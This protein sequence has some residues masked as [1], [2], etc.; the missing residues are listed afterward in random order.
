MTT[1][2]T[3]RG[4][5]PGKRFSLEHSLDPWH[6]WVRAMMLLAL[7]LPLPV[8]VSWLSAQGLAAEL[9]SLSSALLFALLLL[10]TWAALSTPLVL[11]VS[12][13]S[14]TLTLTAR[15]EQASRPQ[16]LAFPALLA[17]AV[18]G[19]ALLIPAVAV[20]W[21]DLDIAG[22][23]PHFSLLALGLL[24]PLG[25][26]LWHNPLRDDPEFGWR[27]RNGPQDESEQ[28]EAEA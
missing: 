14:L 22:L 2:I 6:A 27:R 19:A 17:H 24:L 18:M 4:R 3:D 5:H 15:W 16:D 1:L 8:T 11:L 23:N 9:T 21:I 26:N 28:Q 20:L 13:I 7:L 12:V 25:W 10:T